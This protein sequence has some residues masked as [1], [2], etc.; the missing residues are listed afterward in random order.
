[1]E[2]VENPRDSL[3]SFLL[4]ILV[5]GLILL[6]LFFFIIQTPIPPYPPSNIPDVVIDFEGGGGVSG[7]EGMG[8]TPKTNVTKE[9]RSISG[10]E[11]D[12]FAS[13]E[14]N[15]VLTVQNHKKR[16]KKKA[17]SEEQK[18]VVQQDP[19]PSPELMSLIASVK[20]K[21]K[22]SVGN[23]NNAGG[24]G[25][26]S[27]GEGSGKGNGDG[28]GT[29]NKTGPGKGNGYSLRG[30][31]LLQR[32]QLLD[33]SQEEGTVVVEIVVDETGNVIEANPGLRGSTTTSAY[34]YTLARQAAKTAKFNASPEG[35]HE[36][37]GTYTFVFKLD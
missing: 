26:A 33:N 20:D 36:Q 30:R 37:K 35:I 29:G 24:N 9:N 28:Q 1:M 12:V 22:N 11:E 25:K 7:V 6:F 32:P 23:A 4:S 5:F 8:N 16:N 14:E 13:K 19:Q 17:Q 15:P 27:E 21:L 3:I 31:K 10:G 2:V 34:L 18:V